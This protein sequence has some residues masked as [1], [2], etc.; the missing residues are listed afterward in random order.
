M[1]AKA[2]TQSEWQK[3]VLESPI[4]VLVDFWAVWCGPCRL[5]APIVEEL[6][7][8]YAGKLKVYKVDVDQ[9]QGLAIQ[10]GIM[11]IPTLLLFKNGR[12]VEQIVGA[13]PKGAIE[14]KIAKHLQ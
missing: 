11:S 8:Q 1:A 4:P 2:I 12:V 10:Y 6:A 14:Q 13:L 7:A 9:E 5:I 3:E